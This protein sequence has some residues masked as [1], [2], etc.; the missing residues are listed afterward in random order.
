MKKTFSNFL[1]IG[2]IF[3]AVAMNI[4]AQF[5]SGDGSENNPFII[6]TAAQLAQLA[7]F[8][9]DINMDF[10]DDKNYKLGNDIDLSE[11]GEGFN[12]GDGW[13]PIGSDENTAFKGVFDGDNK[14]IIGLYINTSSLGRVGL[15][16]NIQNSTIKNLGVV[17][18]NINSTNSSINNSIG[19]IVGF[20]YD[21]A[22]INNCFSTGSVSFISEISRAQV[23]GIVGSGN[24]INSY[25][26][27]S[28]MVDAGDYSYAGGVVAFGQVN[29]S[30]S[31]GSVS[32]YSSY[33][34]SYAGGVVGCSNGTNNCYST[35][36]VSAYSSSGWSYAGGVVGLG[37]VN[38]S[39]SIGSVTA[40]SET[41]NSYA[42][43]VSG[44][45]SH[46]S[47]FDCAALNPSMNCAGSVRYFGRILGFRTSGSLSNNIGFTDMINPD[48][49]TTWINKGENMRD[50][51]DIS[52][53]AIYADGTLGGRF[54]E[55]NGWTTQNGKLPG[56]FGNVVDIPD[57]LIWDGFP[58]ISTNNLP[59]GR[60]GVEYYQT[61]NVVSELPISWS[62]EN[63]NLPDG[64]EFSEEGTISGTPTAAGT[65]NFTVMATNSI[66]SD[67]KNLSIIINS[68][69]IITTTNLINGLVGN[70][71]SQTLSSTGDTPIFWTLEINNLPSELE[72]SLDGV[73]SGM[74][75]IAGDFDFTVVATNNIGFDT[76]SF[77]IKIISDELPEIT[78]ETLPNGAV[79]AA[80]SQT[81]TA[82]GDVIM[83][84]LEGGF[85]PPGLNLYSNGIIS[86]TPIIS[87]FFNFIVIT[88][89]CVGFDTK[90]LSITITSPGGNPI[91]TTTS[92]PDGDF[93]EAYFE[94]LEVI[95]DTPV[96]WSIANGVLPDGLNLSSSGIIL[97]LPNTKGLFI[98]EVKAENSA[99]YDTQEL[100]INIGISDISGKSDGQTL[101]A[102]VQDG[103]LYVSGLIPGEI[104]GIYNTSGILVY[105]DVA[106][107]IV[108]NHS[109]LPQISSGV[110][111]IKSGNR[112]VKL[113]I[114]N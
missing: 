23:G 5:S 36:S 56:L 88:T 40:I 63:G 79:G 17:N 69:P 48:G 86:G 34:G 39:Y 104:W 33:G 76:K 59:N 113:R 45:F 68:P 43:G 67:I 112:V 24:A 106:N 77:S 95:S 29:N 107:F 25:S 73:I 55:A 80:Y 82:T 109:V 101:I 19:G 83:W 2:S 85:L 110:Y 81:L 97:G 87:G 71:Y 102:F 90:E 111:I 41:S 74:P 20:C 27:V 35:G 58:Y 100:S 15:F 22:I 53:P 38:N 44:E 31:T 98:F 21:N 92:L 60:I 47:L 1:M 6:T 93:G 114:T 10:Y 12:D 70:Y 42:G 13:I 108:A 57:H 62:I 14:K 65:F 99:G 78:T 103:I 37:Q 8:V 18:M 72:L 28:I 50:G 94:T 52:I 3:F 7:T 91:I 49:N 105:E 54:T 84:S 4:N 26:S 61:F 9:N 96:T 51:E 75:T 11:Y 89:N 66:G 16:G 30:Y 46:F 32:V 64:L